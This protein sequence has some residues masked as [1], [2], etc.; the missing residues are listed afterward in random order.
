MPSIN[1]E[2]VS[3]SQKPKASLI[4]GVILLK[5]GRARIPSVT[6]KPLSCGFQC[7]S[8]NEVLALSN[9]ARGRPSTETKSLILMC[10]T[11]QEEQFIPKFV[12]MAN[13]LA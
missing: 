2:P 10:S 13:Q 7:A 11:K 4:P 9:G 8:G 3:T 1:L 6:E 12:P 5:F